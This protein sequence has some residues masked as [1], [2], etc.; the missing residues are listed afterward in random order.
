MIHCCMLM[1]VGHYGLF[2]HLPP[3]SCLTPYTFSLWSPLPS[4]SFSAFLCIP[5]P[6]QTHT[7]RSHLSSLLPWSPTIT[8][9][10]NSL[11]VLMAGKGQCLHLMGEEL[12][13]TTLVTYTKPDPQHCL[14]QA[15][16]ALHIRKSLFPLR[17]HSGLEN[18]GFVA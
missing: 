6:L 8:Q 14:P 11:A 7:Q 15:E 3:Y 18:H 17:K 9:Q 4:N 5:S 16:P 10:F 1:P 13:T 12:K 2:F